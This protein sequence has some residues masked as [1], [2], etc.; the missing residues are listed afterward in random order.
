MQPIPMAGAN[1]VGYR[2]G[3][4][5]GRGGGPGNRNR[6]RGRGG[7]YNGREDGNKVEDAGALEAEVQI[8]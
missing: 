2:K 8:R 4:H 3:G 7:G 1:Y 5:R 6:R